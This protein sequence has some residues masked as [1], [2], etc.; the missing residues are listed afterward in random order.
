METFEI[1]LG[2][3]YGQRCF[4]R[5]QEQF[6][7]PTLPPVSNKMIIPNVSTFFS[8]LPDLQIKFLIWKTWVTRLTKRMKG[9]G[10]RLGTRALFSINTS[11]VSKGIK[12]IF[13]F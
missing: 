4:K 12:F 8:M 10:H 6:G 13:Y 9:F 3:M 1:K 5:L 2:V 11:N 7:Q